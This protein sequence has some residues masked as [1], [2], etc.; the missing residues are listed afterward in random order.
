MRILLIED[1]PDIAFAISMRLKDEG[2]SVT[3]AHDGDEGEALAVAAGHNLVILDINL[4]KQDGFSVLRSLRNSSVSL[5]VIVIT[6]RNQVA[7]KVGLLD[8]GADDYLVKPFDL[9]ELVARIRAVARRHMGAAQPVLKLGE[10]TIDLAS[11]A[12]MV[13]D[14]P[15]DLGRREFDVLEM[16]ATRSG[17]T[18]TKDRLVLKL[19]GYE[20]AG[21]PNAIELLISRVRR[22]LEDSDLEIVTHRGIGYMLR[23][24]SEGMAAGEA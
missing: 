12:V 23:R 10:V 2:H 3:V 13:G 9:S 6:A 22:K 21:T 20:D 17:S 18:V 8:L 15:L 11:R 24:R 5:P 16:L 1:T 4:P 14:K 7:D 19:F